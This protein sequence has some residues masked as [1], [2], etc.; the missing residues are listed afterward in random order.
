M[1]IYTEDEAAL[2]RVQQLN[3]EARMYV[4][5]GLVVVS[6]AIA[7]KPAD[8]VADILE[9]VRTFDAFTSNNDPY[10]EHDFGSFEFAGERIF[11]KIDLYEQPEVKGAD[12]QPMTTRV[13]T[14]MLADEW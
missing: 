2:A 8:E 14:I 3:D 6:R 11:W 10:G 9:R 1:D 7:A 12:C 5:D 13:L 4:P